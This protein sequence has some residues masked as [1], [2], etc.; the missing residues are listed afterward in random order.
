MPKYRIIGGTYRDEEGRVFGRGEIVELTEEKASRHPYTFERVITSEDELEVEDVEEPE[1]NLP[2]EET[3]PNISEEH[4]NTEPVRASD[5]GDVEEDD[6]EESDDVEDGVQENG[7]E[8][9]PDGTKPTDLSEDGVTPDVPDDYV[10]LSK[11]ASIYDGDE[12]NGQMTADE[13]TSF[14]ETLS[15]TEVNG[16]KRSAKQD[17]E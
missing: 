8:E 1:D 2:D 6:V 4:Q 5:V 11:M 14:F 13:L 3:Q 17:M 12:V 10:L 16:L 9:T 15:P 7:V